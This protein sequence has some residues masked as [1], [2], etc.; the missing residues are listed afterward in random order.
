[1]TL[2][3][4][5]SSS[6]KSL[7]NL[8]LWGLF[9]QENTMPRS[10]WPGGA[11]AAVTFT[12][13]NLGEPLDI[14]LGLW[15]EKGPFGTHSSIQEWLLHVLDILDQHRARATYVVESR[16]VGIYWDVVKNM[17]RYGH[18][19]GWHAINT[20]SGTNSSPRTRRTISGRASKPLI[21]LAPSMPAS[22]LLEAPSLKGRCD[23][24]V[25]IVFNTYTL[26]K[27]PDKRAMASH[28]YLAFQMEGC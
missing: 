10:P 2:A 1:M 26:S 4:G 6:R 16:S 5:H 12:T 8:S 13:D 22:V 27:R 25:N 15:P 21:A 7:V 14:Q 3:T 28:H 17:I 11:K 19:I 18:E 24:M 20:K 23:S 9:Y